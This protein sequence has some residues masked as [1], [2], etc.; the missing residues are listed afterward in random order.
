MR[1]SRTAQRLAAVAVVGF[2]LTS[3]WAA[4]S[5]YEAAHPATSTAPR[6]VATYTELSSSGFVASL[7]PSYL[8]NNSTVLVG[9][10]ITL[11]SP[12]T[13]WIN[14]TTIYSIATNRTAAIDLHETFL[15]T[16]ATDVW[17][18]TLF[19][20]TN[21]TSATT[22]QVLSLSTHYPI[23]VSQI[24][25]LAT[26]I[27]QQVGYTPAVYWLTLSPQISGALSTAGVGASVAADPVLNFSFA[28][29][30]VSPKGL[31]YSSNGTVDRLGLPT[32]S[33]P[34]DMVALSLA[35]GASVVGVA[36]GAWVA[37]RPRAEV[38]P[39]LEELIAPYLEAIAET[40]ATPQAEVT[41][42][43]R[44][45]PD[46]VK[47]ADTLGK[48]ILRPKE[49]DSGRTEFLVLDAWLA[50]SYRYPGPSGA[51]SKPPPPSQPRPVATPLSADAANRIV[52]RIQGEADR[53][54]GLKLDEATSRDVLRRI[55]RAIDLV[56]AR[57]LL[58][59]DM[60]VDE[61]C[62]VIDRAE[63]RASRF[64]PRG[65]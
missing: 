49:R 23:N 17:S 64:P 7:Q 31:S 18:K 20:S 55:R 50:Y 34:R 26:N 38:T 37:T 33:D 56:H 9:G 43:V 63:L 39:P 24:V 11:F 12:I 29:T 30:L 60:E 45:F 40:T 61:L 22:T 35:L 1:F 5:L 19:E 41:I 52:R 25:D 10:N 47:I 2:L 59:A 4:Y 65:A 53:L 16:L 21:S 27:D 14:V 28:G 57:E 13:N 6:V 8:Y 3:I 48:P 46:L 51:D 62:W 32:T 58:E 15:V 42:P 54:R 36:L 44:Q